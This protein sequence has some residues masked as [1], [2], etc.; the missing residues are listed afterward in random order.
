MNPT[1]KTKKQIPSQVSIRLFCAKAKNRRE[2]PIITGQSNLME[3]LLTG[4][5]KRMAVNPRTKAIL[6]TFDPTTLPMAISGLPESAAPKLTNN[7][8]ADVPKEITVTPTTSVEILKCEDRAI[9]PF[10]SK[11]P[12]DKRITKPMM[13]YR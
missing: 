11:S 3:L 8:G 9:P 2:A 5:G 7:S 13:R 12:L 1:S 4:S 10:T 6:D